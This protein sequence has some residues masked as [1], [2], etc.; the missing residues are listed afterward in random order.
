MKQYKPPQLV[1][2]STDHL[3]SLSSHEVERSAENNYI[4]L[5]MS[6]LRENITLI[7]EVQK[8]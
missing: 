4:I 5:T 6:N 7:L 8:F 1:M 3:C 2:S